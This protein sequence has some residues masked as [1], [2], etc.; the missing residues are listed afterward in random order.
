MH[1]FKT[2]D[3]LLFGFQD[4][5]AVLIYLGLPFKFIKLFQTLHLLV[6][7]NLELPIIFLLHLV[8][9]ELFRIPRSSYTLVPLFIRCKCTLFI[10]FEDLLFFQHLN[11][12]NS[13]LLV[14]QDFVLKLLDVESSPRSS[15][16]A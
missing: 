3:T 1:M 2:L 10:L 12:L 5:S 7:V 4:T 15:Y 13:F 8:A 11:P 9:N 14:L 16:V 6:G